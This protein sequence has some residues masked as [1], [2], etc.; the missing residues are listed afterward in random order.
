VAGRPDIEDESSPAD[1]D[2]L[3]RP[4]TSLS[5]EASVI[6]LLQSGLGATV[7]EQRAT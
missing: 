7:I 5:A 2:A 6:A 1:S 3:A 4:D